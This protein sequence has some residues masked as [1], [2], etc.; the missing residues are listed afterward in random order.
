MAYRFENRQKVLTLG[1][2]PVVN[3]AEACRRC[4]ATRQVAE[5]FK[6]WKGIREMNG[7]G[8]LCFPSPGSKQRPIT[9]E[10]LLAALRDMSYSKGEMSIPGFRTI[11]ATLARENNLNPDHIEKQLARK[12]QNAVVEAC[13]RPQYFAQRRELMQPWADYLDL[14]WAFQS[15][16]PGRDATART[17]WHQAW[18]ACFN[19]R[20]P[21]GTRQGHNHAEV[22]QR[23]VSIHASRA[24]RDR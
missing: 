22:R 6:E 24:G 2:Y 3:L 13:D 23:A 12:E 5:Q 14:Q 19:P 21:G 16:R 1:Q 7:G 4:L 17:P 18:A 20:V 8:D 11:F 9:A 15:T 10:G